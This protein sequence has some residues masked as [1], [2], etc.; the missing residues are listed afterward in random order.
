MRTAA[1][2]NVRGARRARGFWFVLVALALGA[3]VG[4]GCEVKDDPQFCCTSVASC[5]GDVAMMVGC[6]DPERSVCDDSG[7][8]GP[9]RTCV[10]DP[11]KTPCDG[12]SD[13]TNPDRPLCLDHACVQCADDAG[14]ADEAPVCTPTTHLCNACQEDID[15]DGRV[16][17]RCLVAT[18]A[19]VGCLDA[20]DCAS[21]TAP[22]CDD[23]GHVCRACRADAECASNLCEEDIGS[24]V[25]AAEIIYVATSGVN[26]GTCTQ[27]AP[28]QTFALGLA[29]VTPTRKIIRA[30][31]GTYVGQ[32]VLNNVTVRIVAPGAIA[33]PASNEMSVVQVSRGADVTIEG[34][35]ITGTGGTND[36]VGVDCQPG[37]G[38]IPTVRLHGT[39]IT[40]NAGGGVSISNCQFSLLNNLITVNGTASQ[41]TPGISIDRI[42]AA[43]GP[44]H[45]IQ[46]NTIASNV[47]G[48]PGGVVCGN[49]TTI[50]LMF[51]NNV[52][53]GNLGN[54]AQVSPS[55]CTWTYSDIG[56]QT[57]VQAGTGNIDSDPL[58]VDPSSSNFHL[59]PAS[60]AKNVA[61]PASVL[62]KRDIDG[63][64]RPQGGR[65]DMGC[66][67]V[68]E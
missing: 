12:P 13:C 56:P 53:Y 61:D 18:G 32:I 3:A 68:V 59:M 62:P 50:P 19:C 40:R 65:S 41:P 5:A 1:G 8:F 9:A 67:E 66:D 23:S 6:H 10:A 25:P 11:M 15:C 28:C 24:C 16:P 37:G 35:A 39:L 42:A 47:A 30:A 57:Q 49:L 22:V 51:S 26:T 43:T 60:P 44:L 63:D 27:A 20:T 64:V 14:C 31:P 46:F 54:A 17:G 4:S 2:V 29:Q 34:L 48:T 45:D 38:A 7:Q 36:P 33:R 58:F 52:I 21:S 55:G